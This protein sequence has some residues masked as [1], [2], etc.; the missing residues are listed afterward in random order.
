MAP[1]RNPRARLGHIQDEIAQLRA[2]TVG[3]TFASFAASY[4]MRRTTEHAILIISEAVRALPQDMIDRHP[5]P[6]WPEIRGIG[7]VLRHD[8]FAVEPPV[9][10]NILTLHL[11]PLADAIEAMIAASD[12]PAPP[13]QGA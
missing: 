2:A 11:P 12:G 8:Y 13:P 7:N 4:V 3:Q 1:S 6:A 9:L 10:W 5:G